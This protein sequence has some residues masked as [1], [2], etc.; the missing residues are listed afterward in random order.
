R[1]KPSF[2]AVGR[3]YDNGKRDCQHCAQL[4]FHG[5][6]PSRPTAAATTSIY[7]CQLAH[8]VHFLDDCAAICAL[9]SGSVEGRCGLMEA[10]WRWGLLLI[11]LTMVIHAAAVV[12][13]AFT[14]LS[15][16]TRL[17][18][19]NLK[20]WHLMAIQ[21]CVIGVIGLLLAALHGIECGIWA[22]VY[23]WLGALD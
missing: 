13:M 16:R 12:T 20:L 8:R 19:R 15:L 10:S 6:N 1:D 11:L 21:I 18:T 9:M 2:C 17:E 5:S 3:Q 22:G 4:R 7:P 23:L 14:G